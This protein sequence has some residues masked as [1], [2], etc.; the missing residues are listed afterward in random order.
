PGRMADQ[1]D[2]IEIVHAG[3]AKRPVGNRKPRRL[4]NMGFDAKA[5]AEPENGAGILGNVGLIKRDPH[6]VMTHGRH[7]ACWGASSLSGPP[8][9]S[10]DFRSIGDSG[11]ALAGQGCQ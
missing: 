4:D 5:R 6:R 8:P 2:M 1:A 7:G 10:Y 9:P 3:A 11:L